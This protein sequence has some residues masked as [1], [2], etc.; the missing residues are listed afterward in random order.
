MAVTGKMHVA[1]NVDAGNLSTAAHAQA[2]A[3]NAWMHSLSS[4]GECL[5]RTPG[6]T[7][8]G[9]RSH[10]GIEEPRQKKERK[11]EGRNEGRRLPLKTITA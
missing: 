1:E 5:Q 6:V 11:A 3:V 4:E 2:F 10:F 8:D 7:N 9:Q